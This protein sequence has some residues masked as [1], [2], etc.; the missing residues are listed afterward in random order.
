MGVC[1]EPN[2]YVLLLEY[3]EGP[4]LNDLLHSDG[5]IEWPDRLEVA[6]QITKGMMHLHSLRPPIIHMD[7]KSKN[8]L[9]SKEGQKYHCKVCIFL[10][11]FHAILFYMHRTV[12]Y[13]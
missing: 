13:R 8:V 11:E 6:N 1:P 9:T 12:P 5:D 10:L 7:L 3:V 2:K 4:D